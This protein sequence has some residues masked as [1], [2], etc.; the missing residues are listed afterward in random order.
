MFTTQSGYSISGAVSESENQILAE[1][2]LFREGVFN[3]GLQEFEDF[4]NDATGLKG[5]KFIRGEHPT[6]D[7]GNLR[8]W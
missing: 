5:V 7:S 4:K 2:P 3:G 6:D 1:G 8:P